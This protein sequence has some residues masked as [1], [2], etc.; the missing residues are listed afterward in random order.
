MVSSRPEQGLSGV[1]EL[2]EDGPEDGIDAAL[3]RWAEPERDPE[4]GELEQRASDAFESALE[5]GR[6][7]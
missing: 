6:Q 7:R 3:F 1:V 4:A 5:R 2:S